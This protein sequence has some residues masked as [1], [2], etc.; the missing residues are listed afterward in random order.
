MITNKVVEQRLKSTRHCSQPKHVPLLLTL[1]NLPVSYVT[2][3][4]H[5]KISRPPQIPDPRS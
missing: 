2:I 4:Q 5:V 1:F 3:R